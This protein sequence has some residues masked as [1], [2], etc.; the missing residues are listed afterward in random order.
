[1]HV[2]GLLLVALYLARHMGRTRSYVVRHVGQMAM[3]R[4]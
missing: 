2:C 3:Q 1:M 4:L